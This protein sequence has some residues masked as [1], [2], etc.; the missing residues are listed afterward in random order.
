MKD[1]QKIQLIILLIGVI[2]C[3]IVISFRIK[4]LIEVQNNDTFSALIGWI[5]LLIYYIAYNV[6]KLNI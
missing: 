2:F 4:A 1:N 6:E 5:T 3:T